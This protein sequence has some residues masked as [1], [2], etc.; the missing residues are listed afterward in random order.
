M[1][2]A[3]DNAMYSS[4]DGRR[5]FAEKNP[6]NRHTLS[7]YRE[8]VLTKGNRPTINVGYPRRL[9]RR[10]L[11]GLEYLW[12]SVITTA[13]LQGVFVLAV[14]ANCKDVTV[15]ESGVP[16]E[17]RQSILK[18]HNELRENIAAGLVKGQPPAGNMLEM[19]WDDDLATSAQ[20]WANRCNFAH[21]PST[22]RKVGRFEIGQNIAELKSLSA[23]TSADKE[24]EL[25]IK[26]WFNEHKNY[27]FGQSVS[28]SNNVEHYTQIA[29]ATTERIGCGSTLFITKDNKRN[30]IFICNYGPR[31]NE[32][33]QSPYNPGMKNCPSSFKASKRYPHLCSPN[34][35][36][37]TRCSP[38]AG[39]KNKRKGLRKSERQLA[40]QN[41]M[42][43]FSIGSSLDDDSLES[44]RGRNY[45]EDFSSEYDEVPL[46]RGLNN[47]GHPEEDDN[48]NNPP[49]YPA[50]SQVSTRRT[51]NVNYFNGDLEIKDLPQAKEESLEGGH[52]PEV[53]RFDL[54]FD[55]D[56]ED[57]SSD[58][59]VIP[60]DESFDT[61]FEAET[62][63]ILDINRD[64][65]LDPNIQDGGQDL[66]EDD[67]YY[68]ILA[69]ADYRQSE[70]RNL[71]N[72]N[73]EE[74]EEKDEDAQ[75]SNY[76]RFQL[77][78]ISGNGN[79]SR[80][81]E[82]G[83]VEG[84]STI[85]P[86]LRKLV[87]SPGKSTGEIEERR[88]DDGNEGN[89]EVRKSYPV[90]N[91]QDS[92]DEM[93]SRNLGAYNN[94]ELRSSLNSDDNSNFYLR[95]M[96]QQGQVESENRYIYGTAFRIFDDFGQ[97][98]QQTGYRKLLIPQNIQN[99]NSTKFS[100]NNGDQPGP[101]KNPSQFEE[102]K[103][104]EVNEP[105]F[106]KSGNDQI[107][108][109]IAEEN[110]EQHNIQA[111]KDVIDT[112]IQNGKY[113]DRI[114][115]E[116]NSGITENDFTKLSPEKIQPR[117]AGNPNRDSDE[118]SKDEEVKTNDKLDASV[119]PD[120]DVNGARYLGKNIN[121]DAEVTEEEYKNAEGGGS[122]LEGINNENDNMDEGVDNTDG[123]QPADNIK[124]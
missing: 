37:R 1:A 40:R 32:L 77:E 66:G 54:E 80:Q 7:R 97:E 21:N 42:T 20:N 62:T 85:T 96:D 57:F 83:S 89:L 34:K 16:C 74:V 108:K 31:G 35:E 60:P 88:E 67:F 91:V 102:R 103:N 112:E 22:D 2:A 29:W 47:K 95:R 121:N 120:S 69:N 27:K 4:Q 61:P 38:S 58:K 3:E 70:N 104:R 118:A 44:W 46:Y 55:E 56:I 48:P 101:E 18:A 79:S 6:K 14:E 92:G 17:L 36:P 86:L 75:K 19:Y 109:E 12:I 99:N 78:S 52:A 63:E 106:R 25:V 71:F 64:Q 23:A 41:I 90:Y 84:L 98:V 10:V 115:A 5:G 65:S 82:I 33:G 26:T 68:R 13:A 11:V 15:L 76:N 28:A 94:S 49:Y 113:D 9:R 107:L 50:I 110:D 53:R 59:G 124:G 122:D 87:E 39:G 100:S 73:V 114:A 72:P 81:D 93:E 51:E 43:G 116:K 8:K 119:I 105:D 117:E 111:R 123:G 30:R 24:F 45:E